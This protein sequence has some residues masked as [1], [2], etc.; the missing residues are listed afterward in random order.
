MAGLRNLLVHEYV[1]VDID[2]LYGLLQHLDDFK[3]FI[4]AIE[5]YTEE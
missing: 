5:Q 3:D 2:K 4:T 1:I